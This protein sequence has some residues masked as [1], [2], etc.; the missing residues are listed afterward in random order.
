VLG[1]FGDEALRRRAKPEIDHGA[2]QQ[3]PGPAVDEDAEIE[4]AHPARQQD[5]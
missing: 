2:H 5:L 1:V 3:Q 4:A